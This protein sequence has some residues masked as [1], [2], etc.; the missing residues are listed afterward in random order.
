MYLSCE[1]FP[2]QSAV[3]R[4]LEAFVL[5]LNSD[6]P[7][8]AVRNPTF[9]A[10]IDRYIEDERLLEIKKLRPGEQCNNELSYGTVGGYLSVLK[11]I[12]ERWGAIRLDRVKPVAVQEWLKAMDAAPKTKGHV[13]ALMHRLFETG[14]AVGDG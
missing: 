9:G 8:L 5:K 10:L 6:H 7:E 11:G 1:R 4:H 12:R 3:E 14:D 2:T 13:K